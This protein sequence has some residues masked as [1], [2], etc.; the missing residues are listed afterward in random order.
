MV[1]LLPSTCH[2]EETLCDHDTKRRR[3][4]TFLWGIWTTEAEVERRQAV[5]EMYLSVYQETDEP[6]CICSL[7]G[8]QNK[9]VALDDCQLADAFFLGANPIGLTELVH[10]NG[11]FPMTTERP[12]N[13]EEDDVY[14]NIRENIKDKKSQTWFKYASMAVDELPLDYIAK[15]DSDTLL[16]THPLFSTQTANG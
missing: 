6:H 3:R 12:A 13:R 5:R 7:S 11:S 2:T 16:F 14:L 10:P 15:V 1:Q 4:P 9:K 8:I